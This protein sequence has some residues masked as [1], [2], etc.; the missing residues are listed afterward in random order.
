VVNNSIK[1]FPKKA[2]IALS[3]KVRFD[4]HLE[5]KGEVEQNG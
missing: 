2:L 3:T 4:E 1:S 5:R